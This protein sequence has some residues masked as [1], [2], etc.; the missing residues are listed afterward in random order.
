M[1][2]YHKG[3]HL[4]SPHHTKNPQSRSGSLKTH[5]AHPGKVKTGGIRTQEIHVGKHGNKF[6]HKFKRGPV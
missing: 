3:K 4:R 6:G 2:V 1:F 5:L